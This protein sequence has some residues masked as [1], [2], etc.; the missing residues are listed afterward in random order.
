MNLVVRP[1]VAADHAAAGEVCVRAYAADGLGPGGY[2]DKLRDVS[3]RVTV[4]S[5][6][7]ALA[8]ATVVGCVTFMPGPAS[9]LS[10]IAR[11]GEAEFRM[12]AVD[13]AAQGR[14]VG[15]A[16]VR[17]CLDAAAYGGSTALVCSSQDR[18]VAAHRLYERLGFTRDPAR[19]WYPVP[20]V[21]LLSFVLQLR[22]PA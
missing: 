9:P 21:L 14:G 19:D 3:S 2:A 17:A 6:L 16:L 11:E 4:A 15:E 12:L 7:V 22:E 20:D 1:A 18:M 5:V 8:D 13:P 10:E